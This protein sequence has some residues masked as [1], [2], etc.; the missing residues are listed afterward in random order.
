MGE[1]FAEL[2]D[3]HVNCRK[4]AVPFLNAG[5]GGHAMALQERGG[6]ELVWLCV[7]KVRKA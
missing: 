1:R 3:E 5:T 2:I 6:H 4:K 7:M